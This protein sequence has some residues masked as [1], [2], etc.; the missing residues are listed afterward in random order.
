MTLFCLIDLAVFWRNVLP[1]ILRGKVGRVRMQWVI[2]VGCKECGQSN[3]QNRGG[4]WNGLSQ[5][6][7]LLGTF[8]HGSGVVN[9]HTDCVTTLSSLHSPNTHRQCC[10]CLLC[11]GLGHPS[12]GKNSR[13]VRARVCS[14][15]Y[16]Y[17]PHICFYQLH[18]T[19][20]PSLMYH[21]YYHCFISISGTYCSL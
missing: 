9:P 17:H 16:E 4:E 1:H 18:S 3:P 11:I 10:I 13:C 21:M 14:V 8:I 20:W 2:Q 7:F 19:G 12:W 6:N 15:V 5:Q